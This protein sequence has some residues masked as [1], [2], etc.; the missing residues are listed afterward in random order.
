MYPTNP[1]TN[2][3]VPQTHRE[4]NQLKPRA[5]DGKPHLGDGTYAKKIAQY[6]QVGL[7]VGTG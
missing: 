1:N 5:K 2:A 6:F 4:H 3:T 7:W